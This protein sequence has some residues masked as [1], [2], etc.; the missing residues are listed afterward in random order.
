MAVDVRDG[1]IVRWVDYWDARHF[2][3]DEAR[4][5]EAARPRAEGEPFPASFG[6]PTAFETLRPT[7]LMG[8]SQK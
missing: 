5:L 2:G 1:Q 3:V 6:V 4:R 8:S 7:C